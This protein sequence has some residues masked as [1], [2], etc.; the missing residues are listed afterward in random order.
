MQ[1]VRVLLLGFSFHCKRID[2]LRANTKEI[3][4][5]EGFPAADRPLGWSLIQHHRR[6]IAPKPILANGRLNRE[7]KPL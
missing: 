7:R 6:A 1:P 5:S 4:S 2:T 3:L